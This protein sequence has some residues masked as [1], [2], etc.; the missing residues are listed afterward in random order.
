METQQIVRR[1][2]SELW[3]ANGCARM[4]AEDPSESFVPLTDLATIVIAKNWPCLKIPPRSFVLLA[5]FATSVIK[6]NGPLT[7]HIFRTTTTMARHPNSRVA[8]HCELLW[9]V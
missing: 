8:L 2:L 1:Q 9:K 4:Q 3:N 7:L 5:Y 6:K